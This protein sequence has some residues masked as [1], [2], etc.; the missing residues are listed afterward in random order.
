[1]KFIDEIVTV[2]YSSYLEPWTVLDVMV[3]VGHS[4]G[5]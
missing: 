3:S 2:F 4:A 5:Q 1:M